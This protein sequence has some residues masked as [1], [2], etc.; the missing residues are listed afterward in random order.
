MVYIYLNCSMCIE[1]RA[2]RAWHSVLHMLY[3]LVL[4]CFL[5]KKH[6]DDLKKSCKQ[7][8]QEEQFYLWLF[9]LH[10]LFFLFNNSVAGN[11]CPPLQTSS[12]HSRFLTLPPIK[13][14]NL[15]NR[16]F[17]SLPSTSSCAKNVS[18][19]ILVTQPWLRIKPS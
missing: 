18:S 1:T 15:I 14:S 5:L 12:N 19:L 6:K 13:L 16:P 4:M 8:G 9:P 7:Q 3:I 17:E 10:L 11:A 2:L